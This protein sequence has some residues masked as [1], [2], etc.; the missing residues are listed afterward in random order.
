MVNSALLNF[1]YF[2]ITKVCIALDIVKLPNKEIQI[3]FY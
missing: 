2:K 3:P 1:S